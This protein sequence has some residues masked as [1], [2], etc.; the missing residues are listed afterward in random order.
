M[1]SRF[2]AFLALTRD[3]RHAF[4]HE[5]AHTLP[6]LHALKTV[7]LLKKP[8]LLKRKKML[9]INCETYFY[10]YQPGVPFLKHFKATCCL[11]AELAPNQWEHH[12]SVYILST[13]TAFRISHNEDQDFFLLTYFV[14]GLSM[15]FSVINLKWFHGMW[16][17]CFIC[18][19]KQS[20]GK[21]NKTELTLS[22]YYKINTIK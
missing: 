18:K 15:Y 22:L 6:F 1:L 16:L 10:F 3:L 14:S 4:E 20:K 21:Q 11:N 19:A 13:F 2:Y 5:E 8:S 12:I 7:H 17:R 9:E